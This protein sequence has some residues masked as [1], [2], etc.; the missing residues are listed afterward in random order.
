[1]GV[2]GFILV[3]ELKFLRGK[4]LVIP[5]RGIVIIVRASFD[6]A[7]EDARSLRKTPDPPG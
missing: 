1:L 3:W 4:G 5:A 2:E 7:Q 6:S